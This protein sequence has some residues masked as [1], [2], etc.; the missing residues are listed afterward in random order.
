ME[1]REGNDS[2]STFEKIINHVNVRSQTPH[3]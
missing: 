1:A 3:P 2:D